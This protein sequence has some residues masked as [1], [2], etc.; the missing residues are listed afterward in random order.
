VIWN[1]FLQNKPLK[2]AW[3]FILRRNIILYF[4]LGVASYFLIGEVR[5]PSKINV[6]HLNQ[7]K[8]GVLAID[9]KL[10][11]D[12]KV[13]AYNLKSGVA[14]FDRIAELVGPLAS[15]DGNLGF[16]YYYLNDYNK[17]VAAYDEAIKRDSLRYTYWWDQGMIYFKLKDYK[18]AISYLKK[19]VES[20]PD[21]P[22]YY[23]ETAKAYSG[24]NWDQYLL[25][26]IPYYIQ[27]SKD[28][29]Q[30][31]YLVLTQCYWHIDEIDKARDA[32]LV[33]LLIAS[34]E[35]NPYYLENFEYFLKYNGE[36]GILYSNLEPKLHFDYDFNRVQIIVEVFRRA[37]D[38]YK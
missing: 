38:S 23:I 6:Y 30:L 36:K 20:I 34:K 1:N 35:K 29:A 17:A 16:C 3:M 27:Q 31:A 37:S 28:D 25:E 9:M 33:G 12:L 21:A 11:K 18:K 19:A 8:E 24:L 7:L 5:F 14:Y 32:I 26:L 4:L 13:S 15:T 2:Q 22:R 10:N